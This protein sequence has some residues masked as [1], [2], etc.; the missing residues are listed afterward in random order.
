MVDH[1]GGQRQLRVVVVVRRQIDGRLVGDRPAQLA[2]RT[3]HVHPTGGIFRE[4]V[5]RVGR[6][7]RAVN[8]PAGEL[9]S[10]ASD[11]QPALGI[12]AAAQLLERPI[13]IIVQADPGFDRDVPVVGQVARVISRAPRPP[14]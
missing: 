2:G 10:S 8:G 5:V 1:I 3:V 7:D 4:V 13:S 6:V 9:E 14:A 11:R 12:D